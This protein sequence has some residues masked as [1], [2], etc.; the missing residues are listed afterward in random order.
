MRHGET[1]DEAE[2]PRGWRCA[3]VAAEPDAAILVCWR[4][5][6]PIRRWRRRLKSSAGTAT[7]ATAGTT[8]SNCVSRLLLRRRSSRATGT[9]GAA[10]VSFAGSLTGRRHRRPSCGEAVCLTT[11]GASVPLDPWLCLPHRGLAW[12][13]PAR[14]FEAAGK[15]F[16]VHS[17]KYVFISY[18][19]GDASGSG[20]APPCEDPQ[21]R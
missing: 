12:A 7:D 18:G 17:A 16:H 19:R 6:S 5:A 10:G 3:V 9:Y 21:Y 20:R 15:R 1:D 8:A 14:L 4:L 2:C 13:V 11:V